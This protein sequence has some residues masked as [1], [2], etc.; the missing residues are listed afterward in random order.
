MLLK[1]AFQS[2]VVPR[3]LQ[4]CHGEFESLV[5]VL[6]ELRPFLAPVVCGAAPDAGDLASHHDVRQLAE[7]LQKQ[8]PKIGIE[9]EDWRSD[10][11]RTLEP[12][13]TL[14]NK[15]HFLKSKR[16]E[17]KLKSEWFYKAFKLNE[18]RGEVVHSTMVRV[19]G[20]KTKMKTTKKVHLSKAI[21]A[22]EDS[23]ELASVLP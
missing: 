2:S 3:L 5:P 12:G 14:G 6:G 19:I 16:S 13:A 4:L 15:L 9:A 11:V 7:L 20:K 23:I 21:G 8:S 10:I 17:T 18:L 1:D 22:L